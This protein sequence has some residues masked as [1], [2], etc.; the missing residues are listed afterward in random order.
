MSN[1]KI[2]LNSKGVKELLK[3][4]EMEE[5]CMEHANKILSKVGEGYSAT[6]HAGKNRV[7]VSVGT[8]TYEAM[9]D[10]YE[11]NTLLKSLRG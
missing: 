10:N 6:T 5:A 7:N 1:V 9:K 2:V 8:E 3:S 11:N 4:Q